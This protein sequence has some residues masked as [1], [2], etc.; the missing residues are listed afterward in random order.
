MSLKTYNYISADFNLTFMN[1]TFLFLKTIKVL[2]ICRG[3]Q[4]DM[5]F[6]V[7]SV[8]VLKSFELHVFYVMSNIFTFNEISFLKMI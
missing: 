8:N 3:C 7:K 5:I 6:V 4:S 1:R 2:L